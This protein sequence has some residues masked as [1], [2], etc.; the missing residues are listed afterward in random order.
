MNERSYGHLN[1]KFQI[2]K[3][4]FFSLKVT[5]LELQLSKSYKLIK[6]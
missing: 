3:I 4:Y 5:P 2:V 1:L 6:Y